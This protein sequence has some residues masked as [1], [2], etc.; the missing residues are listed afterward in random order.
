MQLS[1]VARS[2]ALALTLAALGTGTAA[3]QQDLRSPDT[4]DAAAAAA[5]PAGQDLRSPDARDAGVG[6]GTFSAPR[7]T[8][9][10][11]PERTTTASAG[12]D[13][14]DAAVGAAALLGLVLVA[15]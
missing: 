12:F 15:L 2:T 13:W 6:R 8:V 3:A 14:R 11:V 5:P 9:I 10:R 1:R 4:R 7:V